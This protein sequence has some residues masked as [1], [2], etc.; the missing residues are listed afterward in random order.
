ML[1]AACAPVQSRHRWHCGG[2]L[3]IEFP[4]LT[5]GHCFAI[6]KGSCNPHSTQ[7]GP[8]LIVTSYVSQAPQVLQDHAAISPSAFKPLCGRQHARKRFPSGRIK[9]RPMHFFPAL[10]ISQCMACIITREPQPRTHPAQAFSHLRSVHRPPHSWQNCMPQVGQNRPLSANRGVHVLPLRNCHSPDCSR[11][12]VSCATS[13][14]AS[15]L[16]T[17]PQRLVEQGTLAEHA[18]AM[19]I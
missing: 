16:L 19:N 2:N 1:P 15:D 13:C 18:F 17:Q 14:G 6:I 5:S 12:H 8:C 7:H 4:A 11:Q 9:S 10:I 3:N